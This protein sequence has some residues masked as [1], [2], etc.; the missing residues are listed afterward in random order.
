[1]S[2]HTSR[3]PRPR[4][5]RHPKEFNARRLGVRETD[6]IRTIGGWI[7][8]NVGLLEDEEVIANALGARWMSRDL[9]MYLTIKRIVCLPGRMPFLPVQDAYL[10]DVHRLSIDRSGPLWS[11]RLLTGLSLGFPR[12]FSFETVSKRIKFFTDESPFY[13]AVVEMA[14]QQHWNVDDNTA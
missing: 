12:W 7:Y 5:A 14:A 2:R 13:E 11:W 10:A 3:E 8:K 4:P 6:G 9:L 1:V